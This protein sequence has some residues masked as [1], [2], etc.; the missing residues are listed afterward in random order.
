M[1]TARNR[2]GDFNDPLNQE[3]ELKAKWK[4]D[5]EVSKNTE[6][7]TKKDSEIKTPASDKKQASKK[8]NAKNK[9]DKKGEALPR[10]GQ[11]QIK[12]KNSGKAGVAETSDEKMPFE[13]LVLLMVSGSVS[14]GILFRN[15]NRRKSKKGG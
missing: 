14:A 15:Y 13:I 3:I 1:R 10:W 9:S 12:G 6:K 7:D 4:K 5:D 2:N 11:Y 8:K